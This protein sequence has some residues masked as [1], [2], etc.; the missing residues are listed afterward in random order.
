MVESIRITSMSNQIIKEVKS[1]SHKKGRMK[2]QAI[3][4][5]GWRLVKDALEWGAKIRYFIVSDSFSQKEELFPLKMS[6][7]KIVQV[8]D[9]LFSRIS[10]TESPQG[11]LAVAEKPVYDKKE[12]LR[13]IDRVIAL[14]NI[15][16][17]GNLGTIIRSADACGFDA[18]L[19]SKDSVDPYNPKVIRSTMGS[20]FHIPVIVEENFSETLNELKENS[21]LL[22]AA[23][24]RDS[25]PCWQADLSGKVAII[26]GNE[27]NG[28]S[29][30]VLELSDIAIM[31]P[32]PGKAE[33]LNASAAASILIYECMRQ[34]RENE[35]NKIC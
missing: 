9:E 27:G 24:T 11:I 21:F 31:I 34:K 8:P 10:E 28:L 3:L 17:P 35:T 25:L 20:L 16:D 30:K 14:E 13:R 15:Q 4:L 5:E 32:M 23:H 26:I 29:D 22:A 18:V 33:S 2:A 19:I 7:I 1:L 6:N 12:I